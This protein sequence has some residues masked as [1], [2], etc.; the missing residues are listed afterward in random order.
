M[1][2]FPECNGQLEVH[3]IT[4]YMEENLIPFQIFKILKR[5]ESL[6]I[7]NIINVMTISS[8]EKRV[9]SYQNCFL[10]NAISVNLFLSLVTS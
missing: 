5:V 4:V 6:L 7:I 8:L 2:T 9:M 3:I 1:Y 10:L